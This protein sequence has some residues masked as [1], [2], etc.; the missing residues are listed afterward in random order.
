M[1]ARAVAAFSLLL[2]LSLPGHALAAGELRIGGAVVT[3][4]QGAISERDLNGD[5]TGVR[6]RFADGTRGT[7]DRVVVR[8]KS[9]GGGV[10]VE[11]FH[12]SN[13]IIE[14]PEFS[15]AFANL[16]WRGLR[17]AGEGFVDLLAGEVDAGRIEDIGS[18]EVDGLSMTGEAPNP[19]TVTVDTLRIQTRPVR[20]AALPDKPLHEAT[21]AVR[22]LVMLPSWDDPIRPGYERFLELVGRESLPV[23]MDF[24]VT[25]REGADRVDF[26]TTHVVDIDGL[27]EVGSILGTGMLNSTLRLFDALPAD[28]G[29]QQDELGGMLIAGTVF[30]KAELRVVDSGL[31]DA[32]MEFGRRAEGLSRR[33]QVDRAMAQLSRFVGTFAPQSWRA[34]APPIRAFLATGGVLEVSMR[35]NAPVPM[36]TFIGF[37]VS[38]DVMLS[39]LGLDIRHQP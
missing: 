8:S 10:L 37:T 31:L 13:M 7:A 24:A 23:D 3:W 4:E 12:L 6:I 17:Y 38:P 2:L 25:L 27:G 28:T 26:T 11:R 30:N 36:S 22:G 39:V 14:N 5:A 21:A 32:L 18:L 19:L 20:V 29:P 35:P 34:M 33:Q 15:M 1:A 16:D 9:G